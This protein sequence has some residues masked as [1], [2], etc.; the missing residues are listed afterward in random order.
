MRRSLREHEQFREEL[1]RLGGWQDD[2]LDRA[3][4]GVFAGITMKPEAYPVVDD[5][6]MMRWASS[7]SFGTLPAFEVLFRIVD[8]H[9][10]EALS[11]REAKE[12][13]EDDS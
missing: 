12:V 1:D 8:E 10:V 5:E 2:S 7:I 6:S 3:L 13:P 9:T 11:I 4:R